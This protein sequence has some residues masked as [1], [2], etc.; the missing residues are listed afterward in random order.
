MG[1]S[2]RGPGMGNLYAIDATKQQQVWKTFLGRHSIASCPV[3][4]GITA[5]AAVENGKVYIAEGHIFYAL[6][7]TTG[8]ILWQTDLAINSNLAD[9][10]LW[11]PA[12]VANGKVYIGLASDCDN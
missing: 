7:A 2:T 9:N 1:S 4:Y 11:A 3:A 6:D 5:T 8:T 12:A 10:V